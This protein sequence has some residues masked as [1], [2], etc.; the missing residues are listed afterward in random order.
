MLVADIGGTKTTTA[1]IGPDGRARGHH[2][3]SSRSLLGPTEVL[4]V[5]Q[6]GLTSAATHAAKHEH[7]PV[8]IGVGSAGVIDGGVVTSATDAIIDWTGTDIAGELS[9]TFG[10]PTRVLN[11]VHAHGLGEAMWGAGSGRESMLLVAV[12]TGIGGAIVTGGRVLFGSRAAAGH[13]GHISVPEAAGVMCSCGNTG[14][15]EGLASGTGILRA[16]KRHGQQADTTEDVFARAT[17]GE[18]LAQNIITDCAFAT[19][20]AIGD[21]LNVLDPEVVVVSGGISTT[22]D[23]WWEPVRAGVAASVMRL[24]ADTPIE[25][26][27]LGADAPLIGAAYYSLT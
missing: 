1:W 26:A 20:R 13:I 17:E 9:H 8:T 11:D 7:T 4:S 19:G 16:Y 22:G 23:L 21:L 15:L 14:H 10:L 24:L 2:T 25:P 3:A 18:P 27:T 12:G 6:A 5:V